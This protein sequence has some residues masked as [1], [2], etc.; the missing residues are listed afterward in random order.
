MAADPKT[1]PFRPSLALVV[2]LVALVL[3][4]AVAAIAAGVAGGAA[5]YLSDPNRVYSGL[6]E[7]S[8]VYAGGGELIAS[9]YRENRAYV[10]LEAIPEHT[11]LAVLTIEDDRFYHHRGVD[12]RA[13]GRALWRNARSGALREGGSTITQQLARS[14]YLSR[15]RSITRKVAEMLLAVEVERRLTK[16]EI[17]E[18][19]LN[20]VYFG[21]GAYGIEMAARAYFAKPVSEL[22]LAEGALLAGL[23]RAPSLYNPYR[24]F[25]LALSRQHTVLERMEQLGVV[26][27]D[28]A[29][30]A[31]EARI[32]LAH[33]RNAGFV[34]MRAP[35]ASSTVLQYLIERYGEDLV[36]TGGL[37]VHTTID[38]RM[39]AAAE[40]ALRRGLDQAGRDRLNVTQGAL[41]AL[42]P[43]TG[44]IR[45]MVG[46]YDFEH[47]P[48]NR[49][50]QAQRQ[51]GSAFKPFIYAAAV[52]NGWRPTRLILDAPISYNDGSAERWQPKN[53]DEK[54]RGWVTMRR[55]LEQSINIP[56][57]RTLQSLG[58]ERVISYARRMGIQ[59]PLAPNL[60]LALGASEVTPLEMASAYGTLAAM[61]IRAEPIL[62]LKVV[63]RH[64][65][66]LEENRARRTA[67]IEQSDAAQM[68]DLLKGVIQRGTGRRAGIGRPAAGKTGTS[69][70]YRNAWFIGFTPYLSTA[71]WVGNDDNA[72][73]RRVVGGTVPAGIWASFMR[74][75]AR[76]TPPDDWQG[77]PEPEDAGLP[78]MRAAG[79]TLARWLSARTTYVEEPRKKRER[80]ERHEERRNRRRDDGLRPP[81]VPPG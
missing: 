76:A 17:L 46:G 51:A 68:I 11:R 66:V 50:W 31:R 64:G 34:G 21:Q 18:R 42:N 48:F 26:D 39:Q 71:V 77:L 73:T 6:W 24:N 75:A 59:S 55:A 63:D 47:S 58:P 13:V 44:Y 4:V 40:R 32:R 27:G 35:Y 2:P 30:R 52:A 53:Y 37:Q 45:A 69:D 80:Q 29:D 22:T 3:A 10:P 8:R 65:R 72:P 38:L 57:V 74:V 28:V 78:E 41:V 20:Q 79:S 1:F 81:L 36:Y 54:F 56:A 12:V 43:S 61:G 70:D 19:Y 16:D 60:S 25:E 7:A 33:P 23:I 9:F 62:V 15:R 5:A 67:A 49:A 14:L